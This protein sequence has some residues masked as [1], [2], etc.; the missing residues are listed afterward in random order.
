MALW[1]RGKWCWSDFTVN[2]TRH[3]IP[4]KD[5]RGKRIP[6]NDDLGSKDYKRAL[7]AETRA[8][9][10]A[11]RGELVSAR[12]RFAKLRFSEAADRYLS[13][14][15]P[16]LA[17]R[18]IQTERERVKPLKAFFGTTK[19]S[20]IFPDQVRQYIHERKQAGMANKTVNL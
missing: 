17:P 7:E 18:T 20:R 16:Y 19:L 8:K 4:L 11:E 10:E 1:R 15:L 3:R 2:D 13:D 6:Y 12:Q 9:V 5:Q 14:R